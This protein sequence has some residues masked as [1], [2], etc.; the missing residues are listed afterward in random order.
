M[1][2]YRNKYRY[3]YRYSP[4]LTKLKTV[5]GARRQIRDGAGGRPQSCKMSIFYA[6]NFAKFCHELFQIFQIHVYYN[7]TAV[8]SVTQIHF[9]SNIL[10]QRLKFCCCI[11]DILQP[12]IYHC[13]CK[14][15]HF[16][17]SFTAASVTFCNSVSQGQQRQTRSFSVP[18]LSGSVTVTFTC[19]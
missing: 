7:C 9:I 15:N 11:C 14:K 16:F 13:F 1:Y 3:E 6:S 2:K 5:K 4:S 17:F 19:E 10:R 18:S 8:H 12:K